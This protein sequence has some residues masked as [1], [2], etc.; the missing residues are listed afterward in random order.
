MSD[1][2]PDPHRPQPSARELWR[3]FT[4]Y[5]K[6][7]H[8]VIGVLTGVIAVVIVAALW[9]LVLRVFTSLVL[10]DVFDPTEP[11]VFQMVFGA[12]FT[13]VIALEFK[14]SLLVAAER[15]FG[16]VQV[17]VVVLIALLAVVRKFILLDLTETEAPKVFALGAAVLA[18][19]AVYW[20][21]RDQDR[22]EREAE[23][24]SEQG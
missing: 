4:L 22:R 17:R 12:I 14:R 9:N 24:R 3:G 1:R 20:L 15:R 23:R 16:V 5:E 19:G 8:V 13:T 21:V 18:L 11:A 10:A 7:E 6:F 2:T